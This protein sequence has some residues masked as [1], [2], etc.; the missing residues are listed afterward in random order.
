MVE[1][2][3]LCAVSISG[4]PEQRVLQ[5]FVTDGMEQVYRFGGVSSSEHHKNRS[6]RGMQESF[7]LPKDVLAGTAAPNQIFDR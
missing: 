2:R 7:V 6:H 4:R 5:F 3:N 1:F